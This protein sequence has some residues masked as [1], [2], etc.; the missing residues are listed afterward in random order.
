MRVA[1]A[2]GGEGGEAN[3]GDAVWA[4]RSMEIEGVVNWQ[5]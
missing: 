5:S 1:G 3:E 4:T 2:V